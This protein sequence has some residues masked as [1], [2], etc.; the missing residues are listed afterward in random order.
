MPGTVFGFPDY[1]TTVCDHPNGETL[2]FGV[3]GH[4][5]GLALAEAAIEHNVCFECVCGPC[6]ALNGSYTIPSGRTHFIVRS[7][8]QGACSGFDMLYD[9]YARWVKECRTVPSCSA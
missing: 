8:G 9:D 5:Q 4:G 6:A 2:Q 7:F 1:W 3:E